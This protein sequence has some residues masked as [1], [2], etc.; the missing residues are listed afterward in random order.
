MK[1]DFSN[2][3]VPRLKKMVIEIKI[4]R[5]L[6]DADWKSSISLDLDIDNVLETNPNF[7]KVVRI[8][9]G[10]RDKVGVRLQGAPSQ[11]PLPHCP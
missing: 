1:S 9:M 11:S 3:L 7:S 4:P 8:T 6:A 10:G 2:K 5:G